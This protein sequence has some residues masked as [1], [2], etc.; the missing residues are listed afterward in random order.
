[1]TDDFE[2]RVAVEITPTNAAAFR[3]RD[4][5]R[6]SLSRAIWVRGKL[7]LRQPGG[8]HFISDKDRSRGD[9]SVVVL[10]VPAR[11]SLVDGYAYAG[12]TISLWYRGFPISVQMGASAAREMLAALGHRKG[13]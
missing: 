3:A 9:L 11:V 2:W 7:R 6:A 13:D 10:R 8:L 5:A 4:D 12:R 1:M